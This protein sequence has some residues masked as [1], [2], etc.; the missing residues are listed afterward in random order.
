MNE[1]IQE[2]LFQDR[3]CERTVWSTWKPSPLVSHLQLQF[4][5]LEGVGPKLQGPGPEARSGILE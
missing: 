1:K 3:S 4:C 5:P 2:G